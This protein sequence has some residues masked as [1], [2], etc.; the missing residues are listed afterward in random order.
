[1]E[2]RDLRQKMLETRKSLPPKVINKTSKEI[3]D[4]VRNLDVFK[5][6]RR[7]ASYVA[8]NGEVDPSPLELSDNKLFSLPIVQKN[9]LLK[10]VRPNGIF[11]EGSFGI[12][13]P[14]SGIEE[15]IS[16]LDLVLVPLLA[17]DSKGNRLGYGGGYYDR[18]FALERI[19]KRPMLIGLAH[20]FQVVE[21]LEVNSWDVPL[22]ILVTKSE[23]FFCEISH[24]PV[25]MGE[26]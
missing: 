14:A 16:E 7:I 12:P 8:C 24:S 10:F 5:T 13:E 11:T 2:R 17:A 3:C 21:R 26:Y 25:S 20:S 18:T 15:E 9:G 19:D 1:M 23:V 22:D 6:A 4:L